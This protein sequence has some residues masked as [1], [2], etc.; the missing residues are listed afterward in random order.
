MNRVLYRLM[1]APPTLLVLSLTVFL[2]MELAPGS[3]AGA[4]LDDAA[5][6]EAAAQLCAETHCEAPVLERYVLYLGGVLTG[7][8]GHSIRTGR[9]VG[10][11]IA[12]RLPHTLTLSGAA[13]LL[14]TLIGGVLGMLAAFQQEKHVDHTITGA[15]SLA[16]AMP[17]FW[18]ALLLVAVFSL[19]LGWFPVFGHGSFRHYVLPVISITLALVPGIT[20]MTRSGI[21]ST[22]RRQFVT[23]ARSKG[24][25]PRA[26]FTRH[27]QPVAVIPVVTYVGVQAVHL[28]GS[29]ITI[30]I[31]FNLPGLGGLAVQAALDR[32]PMLLQGV[33][34]CIAVM[35]F[36][37]L[38]VVDVALTLLDPRIARPRTT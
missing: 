21:I 9:S 2:M 32:D 13:I 10:E 29:L 18:I 14:A 23:V 8:F 17:T 35:T 1:L 22:R 30:E 20:L 26:V 34:L 25:S 16:A 5:T 3:A 37:I 4:L 36:A 19:Q 15:A 33:T 6:D 28:I 38:L 24:L 31:I 12:L 11:E 7:D 27:I